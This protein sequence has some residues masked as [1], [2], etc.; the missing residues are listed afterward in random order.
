M[1]EKDI[2]TKEIIKEIGQDIALYILGINID[3]EVELVDKEWTRIEKRESDI[4]FKYEKKIVHI[5]IQNDNHPMMEFRMLRYLSDILFEYKGYEVSQ[6]LIY[7][8][9]KK[10]SMKKRIEQN[11]LSYS[12]DIIDVRDISCEELLYHEHPSAVALSIL[13][14]FEGKDKQM[15]VNTI[16]KRIRELTK[17]DDREYQN[18]LE[19]VTILSSNRDLEENVKEGAKMLAVDIEKIPFYQDGLKKGLE[20]GLEKGVQLVA[21]QMLKLNIDVEIIHKSTGLSIVQIEELKREV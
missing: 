21:V 1:G 6:H 20:K 11:K 17:E 14:D 15:V 13:C 8:G 19:K 7:I 12:Y 3:S 9:Q 5:E 10:C 18:Y 16:L 4:V 2:V